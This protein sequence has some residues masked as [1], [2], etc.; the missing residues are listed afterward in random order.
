MPSEWIYYGFVALWVAVTITIGIED[1]LF[2]ELV[3]N[4]FVI[5]FFGLAATTAIYCIPII[6]LGVVCGSLFNSEVRNLK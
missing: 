1:T 4:V 3:E 2:N 6:I 5:W